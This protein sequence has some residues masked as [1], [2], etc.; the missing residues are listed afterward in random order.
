M[1]QFPYSCIVCEC[2]KVTL[3]EIVYAINEKEANDI[4]KL[5]NITNATT[6]CGRCKNRADDFS[7]PKRKLYIDEILKKLDRYNGR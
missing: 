3:G 2:E 1:A 6:A 4:E 5:A 7:E